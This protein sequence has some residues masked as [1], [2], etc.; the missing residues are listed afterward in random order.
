MFSINVLINVA[1][2]KTSQELE[3]SRRSLESLIALS[4]DLQKQSL[5][6]EAVLSN[7]METL[8]IID[9]NLN[10]SVELLYN[11]AVQALSGFLG[12]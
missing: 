7:N 4:D 6:L 12:G 1:E 3:V 10:I 5:T 2:F 8:T 9:S 11:P